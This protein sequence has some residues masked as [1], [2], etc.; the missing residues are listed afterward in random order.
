MTH[1]APLRFDHLRSTRPRTEPADLVCI[2]WTG[3]MGGPEQVY[4]TL[5]KRNLSIHF[6]IGPDGLVVQMASTSLVCAHAGKVNARS[7]GIEVVSPGLPGDSH[8]NARQRL[9]A[10][11]WAKE[12]A[13]GVRRE[14]YVDEIRGRRVRMLDFTTVQT[15]AL[16][17]LVE[18]LCD[19]LGIPKRVPTESDGSLT[20][21]S[22]TTSELSSFRGVLGHYG[23]HETKLDCGTLP[24]ERL[25]NRWL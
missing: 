10:S 17:I 13:R 23:A 22:L 6:V 8:G 2:H 24:L 21:R 9:A 20:R 15:E 11:V 25:R 3:G 5:L 12:Q 18:S 7:V 4:R 19:E 14:A 16:T 1:A